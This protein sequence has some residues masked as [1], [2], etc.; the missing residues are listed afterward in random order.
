MCV[1]LLDRVIERIVAFVGALVCSDGAH[2]IFCVLFAC[3]GWDRPLLE[4]LI[5]PH[6][7]T[8]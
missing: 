1:L 6:I 2:L 3:C 8:R 4:I 7:F 5:D